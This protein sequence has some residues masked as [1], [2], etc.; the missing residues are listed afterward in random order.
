[1]PHYKVSLCPYG[2]MDT[3]VVV[4]MFSWPTE[5]E[6]FAAEA[7]GREHEV[8][9]FSGGGAVEVGGFVVVDDQFCFGEDV[10]EYSTRVLGA[11]A[12]TIK[13]V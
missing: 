7:W 1:M 8:Q 9:D 13:N 6:Y 11:V 12:V 5:S 3:A 10:V 4:G 2:Y